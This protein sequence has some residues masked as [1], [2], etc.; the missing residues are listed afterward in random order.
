MQ[1]CIQNLVK[2]LNDGFEL[3]KWNSID[4]NFLYSNKHDQNYKN[5]K[6]KIKNHVQDEFV[7]ID[8]I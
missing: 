4:L 8:I 1:F 7:K 5:K 6:Q 3:T 2:H